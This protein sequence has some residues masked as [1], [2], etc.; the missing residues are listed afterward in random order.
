L[1][2]VLDIFGADIPV[3]CDGNSLLPFLQGKTPQ[4][5]RTEA[6]WEVDFRY[7][8]GLDIDF[9]SSCF[10]VIRDDRYKYVHFAAM[11]PLFF[12]LRRDPDELHNLADDPAYTDLLLEYAQKMLSWRMAH[13]ER[14][15][16]HMLAE[17]E[18]MV[19]RPRSRW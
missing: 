17:P 14:T 11:P 7:K 10:N 6:H 9:N 3:Q 16:T 19:E 2:T 15:L 12:D 5:W 4:K 18:G 8:E 13:D 1:P